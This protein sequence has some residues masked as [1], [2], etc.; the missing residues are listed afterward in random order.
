MIIGGVQS[1]EV[2]EVEGAVA[3]LLKAPAVA[4]EDTRQG[5]YR[6]A[7]AWLVENHPGYSGGFA[8]VVLEKAWAQ[9]TVRTVRLELTSSELAQL[10]DQLADAPVTVAIVSLR[11]KVARAIERLGGPAAVAQE[12]APEKDGDSQ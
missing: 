9:H 12:P 3:G 8:D 4:L 6:A 2:F 5:F 10:A 1:S 11:C 7:R